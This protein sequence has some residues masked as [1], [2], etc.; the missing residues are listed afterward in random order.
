M[1]IREIALT[2]PEE[3]YR[4]LEVTAAEMQRDAKAIIL[5]A[6]SA[7]LPPMPPELTAELAAWDALS[8]EAFWEFERNLEAI[9]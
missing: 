4:Q 5:D 8:D 6:L 1:A 2:V 7:Y 3:L 9:S